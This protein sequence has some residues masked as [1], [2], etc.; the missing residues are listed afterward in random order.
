MPSKAADERTKAWLQSEGFSL[1]EDDTYL[2]P[3]YGKVV[4][5][6]EL[7]SRLE[8]KQP[9]HII[10]GIGGGPQEKLGRYLRLNLSYR[11]AI[12]C[13]GAAIGF[14]TGDQVKVP[15]WA[16]RLYLGWLL[17]TL[18]QPRTYL[19]RYWD[20]RKLP[21]LVWKYRDRLPPIAISL[22]PN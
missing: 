17:R 6:P 2:A 10:I 21:W 16:D 4:E 19:P 20:A 18:W 11:P 7:V 14:L 1:G 13:I 12:H 5:D 22:R 15:T 3:I 9:R 8:A